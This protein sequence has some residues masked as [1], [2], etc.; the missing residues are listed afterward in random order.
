MEQYSKDKLNKMVSL[1]AILLTGAIIIVVSIILIT[2]SKKP[3]RPSVKSIL[4]SVIS[5]TP[6]PTNPEQL[7]TLQTIINDKLTGSNGIY[8]I[9]V[10][11]LKTGESFYMND[12]QSFET[13]SL[14]KLWVMATAF[15]QIQNGELKEDTVLSEYADSLNKR[16]NISSESAQLHEGKVTY[17]VATALEKMITIS[18]N[19]AAFLLTSKV[20]LENIANFL[21][22]ATLIDSRIGSNGKLPI[23]TPLDTALLIAKLYKGELANEQYTNKMLN[24]LKWQKLNNKIPKYLPGNISVLHK[25]GELDEFTHDAGIVETLYGDYIMVIL[26]KSNDPSNAEEHIAQISRAVYDYFTIP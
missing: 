11:N 18:D 19:Y 4:A 6:K 13:A 3:V 25:T 15:N 23:T 16:Y 12:Q 20:K 1:L 2:K 24:L 14:Y 8:G 17:T 22:E 5:V 21:K 10:L 26:T 7:I 9:V